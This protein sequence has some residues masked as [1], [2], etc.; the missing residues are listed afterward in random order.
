MS[1]YVARDIT[2]APLKLVVDGEYQLGCFNTPVQQA[3]LLDVK[4]TGAFPVPR[5]LKFIQLRE[6]QAFQI[7]NEDYFVMIAIY[8]AKKI[9]LVQFIVYNLKTKEKVKYEK[10]CMSWNLSVPDT[11]YNSSAS[12]TSDDFNIKVEHDLNTHK[13]DIDVRIEGFEGLPF[14]EAK[15]SAVHD[16]VRYQ[17]MVVCNPFSAEAVMYSHKCLMPVQGSLTLGAQVISF[18]LSESQLIIDDHKGYYPYVTTYD[19]VTGLG[20]TPDHKLIGFNLTNNQVIEQEKYNEN[21][22]WL[23]GQLYPL[24]PITI[25]RPNGHTDTWHITDSHDMVQLEF[26]P[27]THTSVRVN[28]FVICSEYEGPYGYYSGYIRKSF[29]GEKVLIENMFGMGEDFYLRA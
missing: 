10:K 6:W 8:N 9:S 3:N 19:W 13:L 4:S 26:T 20:T 22:L 28:Y 25:S 7:K 5:A 16:T 12:Y 11:L 23:D 17:P 14:V 24:P 29:G 15:F 27:V 18:P 2:A 1:Q 21:C